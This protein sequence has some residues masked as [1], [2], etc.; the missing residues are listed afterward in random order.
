MTAPDVRRVMLVPALTKEGADRL[1][2][3]AR[4]GRQAGD[5]ISRWLLNLARARQ[6]GDGQES[7]GHLR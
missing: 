1:H 2:R 6:L 3:N 7:T 5:P 4:A